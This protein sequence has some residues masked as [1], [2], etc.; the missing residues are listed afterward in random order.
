[1]ADAEAAVAHGV[2]AIL[3][4]AGIGTYRADG[5]PYQLGETAIVFGDMPQQPN[6]VIAIATYAVSDDQFM[7]DSTIGVQIKM[8]GTADPFSVTG[9]AANIFGVLQDLHGT[10]L[11]GVPVV[12][13]YRYSSIPLG[14]DDSRRRTRSDNYYAQVA[15]A[16]ANRTDD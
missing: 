3:A 11:G 9:T 13:M 7:T 8:R 4:A 5:S 1:M 15:Y 10:T 12:H 6:Q 16:T 14:M 2:A